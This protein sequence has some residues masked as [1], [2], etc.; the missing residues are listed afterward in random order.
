MNRKQLTV[1]IVV[2]AVIVALGLL[3]LRSKRSNFAG[4][5]QRLGQPVIKNFP[6]NDVEQIAIRQHAG[7]LHLVRKT[8]TWIVQERGGY[9]ANFDNIRDLLRKVWELKVAQ[10]IKV[11]AS[12]L[13]RLELTPPEKGTNAGTLVEFKDKSGKV[14]NSLVLGKKHMREGRGDSQFGGGGYPDGRFIMVGNDLQSVAVVSEP[15]SNVE[16]KPADWLNKDFFKVEKL[17]SIAV[18]SQM[19]SNNWAMSR[20]SET[21]DWKLLDLK[22]GEQLDTSKSSTVTS[23]LSYPSFT[24]VATNSAPE[25]TGLDKPLQAKLETL[26]GFVYQV[27]VGKKV[28]DDRDDHYLKVAVEAKM[29]KERAPGKDEKPED[30]EKLDKEFKANLDK[31]LEKLKNE[32]ALASWTYVVPKYSIEPLLKERKDL[33]AE[34]K[35]EK[36]EEPAKEQTSGSPVLS[37]VASSPVSP[38]IVP[39]STTTTKPEVKVE[40]K[41]AETK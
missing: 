14:L 3:S 27:K 9:P 10:P 30:K 33:L 23:A 29:P 12:L 6:M 22:P 7:E 11:G 34:K 17:K 21:N 4:S 36:K 41:P 26:D 31:Q 16:A 18:T 5:N 24:D 28:A 13:P 15:F 32:Q 2:G 37:P 40:P 25:A 1:L 20:D 38:T 39:T 8:D 19:A 35:D